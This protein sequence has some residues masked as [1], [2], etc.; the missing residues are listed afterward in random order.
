MALAATLAL[1]GAAHAQTPAPAP[2]AAPA[3]PA[4]PASEAKKALVARV[5]QLQQPGIE[6]MARQLSEQPARQLLQRAGQVLQGLPAER[7][8]ALARDIEADA[9][10]YAEEAT[11]IV[12]S[13]AVQLAPSTIGALLEERMTEEELREVIGILE[14]AANRKF[15]QLGVDMQRAIGEKLVAETRGEISPK[16]QALEQAVAARLQPPADAAPKPKPSAK[17]AAPAKK[18]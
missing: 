2:A 1:A 4:A 18:P 9:R 8:E 17:P 10:R 3:A 15:Q 7:R 11:P 12:V 16:V 14:S 6:A 13:R 5:L